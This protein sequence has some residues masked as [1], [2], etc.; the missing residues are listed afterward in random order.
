MHA[1]W[2]EIKPP[3]AIYG[4]LTPLFKLLAIASLRTKVLGTYPKRLN[5]QEAAW[6]TQMPQHQTQTKCHKM[7][8]YRHE[9]QTRVALFHCFA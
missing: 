8:N 4:V 6:Q 9:L 3:A 5:F 2:G 7:L 1:H